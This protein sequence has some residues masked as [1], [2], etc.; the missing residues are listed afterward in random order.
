[1]KTLSVSSRAT[2]QVDGAVY[3]VPSRWA[4]LQVTAYIGVSDIRLVCAGA[5]EVHRRQPTGGKSVRYRHYLPELARKPQAVRQVAPE[6]VAELGEPYGRLWNLLEETHGGLEAART[7]ARLLSAIT[8]HGEETV[9]TLLTQ[10]LAHPDTVGSP[11]RTIGAVC[12]QG[13]A[14]PVAVPDALLGYDIEAGLA[15]DYDWLLETGGVR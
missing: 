9:A 14:A 6:L 1:M 10:A 2:V 11:H 4:R 13:R 3:P 7:L 5:T 12:R 15:A 8:I